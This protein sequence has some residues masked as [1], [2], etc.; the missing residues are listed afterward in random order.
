MASQNGSSR[1]ASRHRR[2]AGHSA[3]TPEGNTLL[4]V[5]KVWQKLFHCPSPEIFSF[6]LILVTPQYQKVHPTKGH[7]GPKQSKGSTFLFL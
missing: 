1:Y 4:H 6:H 7:K 2:D 5:T 3:L